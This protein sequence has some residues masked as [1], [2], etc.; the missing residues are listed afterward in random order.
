[1]CPRSLQPLTSSPCREWTCFPNR[2]SSFARHS[3]CRQA[4]TCM[5]RI[6]SYANICGLDMYVLSAPRAS[7]RALTHTNWPRYMMKS[8]RLGGCVPIRLLQSKRDRVGSHWC[9]HRHEGKAHAGT[10]EIRS[11]FQGEVRMMI[12]CVNA[13]F[14][15]VLDV[16]NISSSLF[17]AMRASIPVVTA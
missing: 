5:Q 15:S 2:K 13:D 3:V 10:R 4:I 7:A 17:D 14:V 12:P 11:R 9:C 16:A 6:S 8:S 1:M